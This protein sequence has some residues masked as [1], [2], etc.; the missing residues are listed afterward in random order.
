MK[1]SITSISFLIAVMV[2]CFT[3][4]AN[5]KMDMPNE[6]QE[7]SLEQIDKSMTLKDKIAKKVLT[8]RI[9]KMQKKSKIFKSNVSND[10]LLRWIL[11]GVAVIVGILLISL[12]GGLLGN[13][14]GLLLLVLVVVLLLNLLGIM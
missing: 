11:I 1:N 4:P 9:K 5:A 7:S 2:F 3:L 10:E 12:L 14:L 8:K 13:L 6:I